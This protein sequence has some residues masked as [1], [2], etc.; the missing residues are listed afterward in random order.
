MKRYCEL[1]DRSLVTPSVKRRKHYSQPSTCSVV[2]EDKQKTTKHVGNFITHKGKCT[3]GM[4][5]LE[6]KLLRNCESNLNLP[7]QDKLMIEAAT[8]KMEEEIIT[9]E[10]SASEKNTEPWLEKQLLKT[11]EILSLSDR[12]GSMS[13]LSSWELMP[14]CYE[15]DHV[16]LCLQWFLDGV[17]NPFLS[18]PC[19]SVPCL[20]RYIRGREK[21]SHSSLPEMVP[22]RTLNSYREHSAMGYSLESWKALLHEKRQSGFLSDYHLGQDFWAAPCCM[23]CRMQKIT[24]YAL[25]PK[26]KRKCLGAMNYQ[27]HHMFEFPGLLPQFVLKCPEEVSPEIE[28]EESKVL[29]PPKSFPLIANII[30]NLSFIGQNVDLSALYDEEEE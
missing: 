15:K 3:A 16:R 7:L 8:G 29:V 18:R 10:E 1:E 23:L 30:N 21:E 17:H 5:Q 2:A 28:I 26:T 19:A 9:G 14:I 4:L 24:S 27:K 12:I 20:G 13:K 6:E 22:L 11:N 25:N